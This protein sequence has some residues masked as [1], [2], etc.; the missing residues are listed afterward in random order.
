MLN[1]ACQTSLHWEKSFL[2]A[3]Y[4]LKGYLPVRVAFPSL[5]T[6]LLRQ[7]D[8]PNRML[9]TSFADS[10][11]TVECQLIKACLI[12]TAKTFST[13]IQCRLI[14]LFSRFGSRQMPNP[15]NLHTQIAQVAKFQFLMKPIGAINSGITTNDR[16]FWSQ[17]SIEELY[18]LYFSLSATPGRVLDVMEEPLFMNLAQER[19]YGYPIGNFSLENTHIFLRFVTGNEVLTATPIQGANGSTCGWNEHK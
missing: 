1:L 11:S 5:A 3:G 7:V 17:L 9:I 4:L 14:N 13:G 18:T 6:M 10:L 16:D 2:M 8:I 19:V 12:I 15:S